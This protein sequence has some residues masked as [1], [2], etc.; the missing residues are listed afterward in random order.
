M[1][2]YDQLLD[3]T[4]SHLEKLKGRGVRYVAVRPSTL[5]AMTSVVKAASVSRG[6]LTQSPELKPVTVRKAEPIVVAGGIDKAAAVQ[7][8]RER[9]LVCQ[10]CA[11]LASSRK[12]VVFG[13]GSINA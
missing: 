5:E 6:S 9:A 12:N 7:E 13:V 10:K 4:I 8:L 1:D 3:A 11:N 2:S